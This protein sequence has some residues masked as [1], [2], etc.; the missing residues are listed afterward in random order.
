MHLIVVLAGLATVGLVLYDAF[1]TT[2][3]ASTA[4]GPITGRVGRLL[5][6]GLH[7]SASSPHSRVLAVAGPFI[8]ATILVLWILGLWTGWSVVFAAAPDAV[9]DADTG[10]PVD[11]WGRVYYAGFALS[12]L[13]VGDV[14]AV[15][16]PWR[17]LTVVATLTG[18]VLLT[19]AVSFL[20]PVTTAVTDAQQQAMVLH[21]LGR[22]AQDIVLHCWDCRSFAAATGHLEQLTYQLSR[23]TRQFLA[24]PVLYYFHST[25]R[26]TSIELGTAA[27]NEAVLLLEHG[28]HEDV[29]LPPP[30]VTALRRCLRELAHVA[31]AGSFVDPA[32]H[33]PPPP[34]LAP[35]RRAGIPTVPPE[36]FRSK[37]DGRNER[38]ALLAF[39]TDA[40]WRW[41]DCVRT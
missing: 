22:T 15:G 4:S 2:L 35:L 5:W 36:E 14:V 8:V 39:V 37:I 9:V 29:R 26:A 6:S 7:R 18:F 28:I 24:Y 41:E 27:L 13:G 3:S 19:T 17:I 10:N 38:R 20:I 1:I 21:A 32:E 30:T 40:G 25:Q 23:T 16:T 33:P 34:D 12:T 31:G 11:L